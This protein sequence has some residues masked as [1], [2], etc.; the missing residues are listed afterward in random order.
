[1][2]SGS[3]ERA[4]H[5]HQALRRAFVTTLGSSSPW[6]SSALACKPCRHPE[7]QSS[8]MSAGQRRQGAPAVGH[9][10]S[11][12]CLPAPRAYLG[13]LTAT[14]SEV[15]TGHLVCGTV[16]VPRAV[17]LREAPRYQV[18]ICICSQPPAVRHV[19]AHLYLHCSS[20]VALV[21]HHCQQKAMHENHV[22]SVPA[23]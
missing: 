4:H 13:R 16:A 12:C 18:D 23:A 22:Q 7:S 10:R 2:Q 17:G 9:R 8:F 14:A 21:V 11:P 1:M 20:V 19:R 15:G 3:S 5:G 6:R